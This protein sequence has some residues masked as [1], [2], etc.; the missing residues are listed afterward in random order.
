MKPIIHSNIFQTTKAFMAILILSGVMSSC[1]KKFL[2]SIPQDQL[3]D[4]TFWKTQNDADLA[5]TGLYSNWE[6]WTRFGWMDMMSDLSYSHFATPYQVMGNGQMNASNPGENFFSYRQI[7]KYNN[8]LQKIDGVDMDPAKKEVYKAEARFLRAYEYFIKTECYGDVPL[9]TKTFSDPSQAKI[10]ASPKADVVTFI[11]NEL[12]TI[13]SILPVQTMRQSNGH[14]TS[15]AAL[16]LKAKLELYEGMF[17]DAMADAK[18]VMDMGI[19]QLYPDFRGLFLIDNEPANNES[20]M[21]VEFLTNT[22]PNEI[23]LDVAPQSEG[24]YGVIDAVQNTVN[25]Y[26]MANGK[27]IDDPTSGYDPSQPFKN[28]DPRMDMTVRHAGTFFNNSYFDP[29]TPTS[30]DYHGNANT[31]ASGLNVLKF[32]KV[33]SSDLTGN[34][35]ENFMVLRYADVLLMYAEAAI[36][37]GQITPDVYAAIDAVRQ[38]G[39]M[40]KTDQTVY[41]NQTKLR[42]LVR[43]ER[44]A[45]LVFEGWRYFDDKRWDI[46]PQVLNGPLYGSWLGT[47]N[48]QTGVITLDGTQILLENRVF[49]PERKYL[50]PIPQSELD[51]N[52]NIKQ[53]PGY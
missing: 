30:P 34:G 47:M 49:H 18:K 16:T 33:V 31:N 43:R 46:G 10:A 19:Y 27:T 13:S 7:T 25:N 11:L 32:A 29:F 40:P 20:I 26:E 23:W 36:E 39:G 48:D 2:T 21:E 41:N 5:L 8:F 45:E 37:A 3:S 28:R 52:P 38:R 12:D 42:E 35:G 15:G 6:S 14:A 22:Y 17:P 50:L 53:N 1:S 51:A 4:G 44:G 9:V 24:G